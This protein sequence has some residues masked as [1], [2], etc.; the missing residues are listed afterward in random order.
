MVGEMIRNN[1]HVNAQFQSYC[2]K[3]INKSI[4]VDTTDKSEFLN[5]VTNLRKSKSPGPDNIST[6]LIKVVIE[7]IADLLLYIYIISQSHGIVPEKNW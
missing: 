6:G 7:T 3:A 5:L 4:Y 2:H 1:P